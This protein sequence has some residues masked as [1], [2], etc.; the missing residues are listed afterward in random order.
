MRSKDDHFD[1]II[2]KA[3]RQRE[4]LEIPTTIEPR[5]ISRR[6]VFHD[7]IAIDD[8]IV[9]QVQRFKVELYYSVLDIIIND[10]K[11]KVQ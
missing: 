10:I 6:R 11:E 3:K 9:D 7:T 4:S 1:T 5:R 8:P 2:V